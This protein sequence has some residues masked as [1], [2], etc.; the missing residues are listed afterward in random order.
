MFLLAPAGGVGVLRQLGA[1][2]G[3]FYVVPALAVPSGAAVRRFK[4][5]AAPLICTAVILAELT[6][7]NIVSGNYEAAFNTGLTM[8][9]IVTLTA[10][11]GR[12][13]R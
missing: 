7:V 9:I 11:Y 6:V 13:E 5:E 1:G 8:I 2:V 12:R 4:P 3:D 10:M